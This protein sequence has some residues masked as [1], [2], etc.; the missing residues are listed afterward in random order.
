[1]PNYAYNVVYLCESVRR[2]ERHLEPHSFPGDASE[3]ALTTLRGWLRRADERSDP[4]VVVNVWDAD[5]GGVGI[6]G[7][8]VARASS[9]DLNEEPVDPGL[10]YV[11][12]AHYHVLATG[13][14]LFDDDPVLG[15]DGADYAH[16]TR[17]GLVV[18]GRGPGLRIK[19]GHK[20][21]WI[22]LRLALHNS[23]PR[24][25]IT[26]WEAI[27]EATIEPTGEVRIADDAGNIHQHYPDLTDGR[28]TAYL[29]IRVSVR[30]R[31]FQAPTLGTVR[32][33]HTP[34]E[35]HLIEAWAAPAPAPWRALKR[36]N[37]SRRFDEEGSKDQQ[38]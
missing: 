34:L 11:K 14:M 13:Y 28:E 7:N 24:P 25:D 8:I 36:D 32:H 6:A 2:V 3:F 22:A 1:M 30:G 20:Y 9:T 17:H 37:L 12:F 31:D 21:G 33:Q 15:F 23:E 16:G 38:P 27:E 10:I 19:A 26:R 35:H 5:R 29:T 18:P 4:F